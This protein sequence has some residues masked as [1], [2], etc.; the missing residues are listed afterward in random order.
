MDDGIHIGDKL[1]RYLT[2]SRIPMEV[3]VQAADDEF[4]WVCPPGLT[5]PKDECWKFNRETMAEV[6]E[7]FGDRC[8]GVASTFSTLEIPGA[9]GMAN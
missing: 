3:E 2:A 5:W 9:G 1:M 6:D 8:D 4:L 7:R